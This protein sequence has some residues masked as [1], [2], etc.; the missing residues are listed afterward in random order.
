MT[1][2]SIIIAASVVGLLLNTFAIFGIAWRGGRLLGRLEG[3]MENLTHEQARLVE[4]VDEL[5][6]R[7]GALFEKLEARVGA[8]EGRGRRRD[9][10]E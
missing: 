6:E 7:F 2:Q 4:V 10:H 8:L 5:G 3:S 1:P 9:D